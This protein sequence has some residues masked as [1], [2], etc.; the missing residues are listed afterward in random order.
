VY[1]SARLLALPLLLLPALACA[2]ARGG[3]SRPDPSRPADRPV[4]NADRAWAYLTDQVAFGP[5]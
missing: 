4:F 5:R 3:P 2:D 1:R